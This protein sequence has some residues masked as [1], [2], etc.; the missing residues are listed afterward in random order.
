MKQGIKYISLILFISLG[1]L[2][3]GGSDMFIPQEKVVQIEDA[4]QQIEDYTFHYILEQASSSSNCINFRNKFSESNPRL[5]LAHYS[6]S[7]FY[8]LT[9]RNG[10]K[11][12]VQELA[13]INFV[14]QRYIH[15]LTFPFH[16]FT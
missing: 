9:T 1:Y 4:N 10:L 14:V 5:P 11:F 16:N 12:S 15:K 13:H 6:G 7:L 2:V 8:E 3:A